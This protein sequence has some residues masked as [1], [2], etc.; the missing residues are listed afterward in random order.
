MLSFHKLFGIFLLLSTPALAEADDSESQPIRVG[1]IGAGKHMSSK[2]KPALFSLQQERVIDV[3]YTC[4]RDESMLSEQKEEWD[5]RDATT[6]PKTLITSGK[7]QAVIAAGP[8]ALPTI[9]GQC[10]LP[11]RKWML[12]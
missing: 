8:P 2:L 12:R 4:R 7:V 5:A 11:V 3:V 10:G 6:D 1:I 9:S